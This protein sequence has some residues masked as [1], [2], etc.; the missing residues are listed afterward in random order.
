MD[1][2]LSNWESCMV[3]G[4]TKERRL[5]FWSPPLIGMLKFNVDGPTRGKPGR[6]VLEKYCATIKG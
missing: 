6:L 1:D 4:L 3:C 5:T 2:S